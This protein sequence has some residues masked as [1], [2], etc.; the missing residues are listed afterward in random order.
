MLAALWSSA[1]HSGALS[2]KL[3]SACTH[4]SW[5]E[6][7]RLTRSIFNFSV[8]ILT[9][10]WFD[11]FVGLSCQFQLGAA[12]ASFYS[13]GAILSSPEENK[14]MK[15]E[16]TDSKMGVSRNEDDAYSSFDNTRQKHLSHHYFSLSLLCITGRSL[17]QPLV[18]WS[19]L[20]SHSYIN[21]CL[22]QQVQ[23]CSVH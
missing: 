6:G 18:G 3:T 13:R 20:A 23:Q 22:Q 1:G 16:G 15:K 9:F 5:C 21:Q 7:T 8:G 11:W 12:F 17:F 10:V 4:I 2:L 19:L 14:E